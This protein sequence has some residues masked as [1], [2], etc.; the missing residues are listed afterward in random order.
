MGEKNLVICDSEVRYAYGLGENVSERNELDVKVFVCTDLNHVRRFQ[1]NKEIHILMLGENVWREE[2]TDI[3]ADHIFVLASQT[4]LE[5]QENETLIYRFQAAD[6][7]FSSVFETYSERTSQNIL[8][9]TRR[10]KQRMIAVYSPIHR[11][12]KT[13]FALALGKELARDA[14]TLYINLENYA[15][16]G[17]AFRGPEERN[18]G[19][20]L[21]Y[22]KQ[23]NGNVALRLSMM[24]GKTGDLHYIPP[25]SMCTDLQGVS[26]EEWKLL[27]QQIMNDGI[28]ENIVLDLGDCVQG[29]FEILQMC[30]KVYMPVL[31]DVTSMRKLEQFDENIRRQKLSGLQQKICR[32][33]ATLD[34]EEYAKQLIREDE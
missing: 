9:H 32:F 5:L 17:G 21:Y 30:D 6:T 22:M 27:F 12:G 3:E 16:L 2:R 14:K 28:F 24:V 29:L 18:L 13:T 25:I 33:T 10:K 26:L 31:E 15:G 11:I 1:K 8:K 7:I 19:D 34:M 4:D 20:L 23:E